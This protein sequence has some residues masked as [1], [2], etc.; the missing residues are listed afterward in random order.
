MTRTI[1]AAPVLFGLLFAP[2]A[3][4]QDDVCPDIM[5]ELGAEARAMADNTFAAVPDRVLDPMFNFD[6]GTCQQACQAA[7]TG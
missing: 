5:N 7:G 1:L 4:A 2:L 6:A 3:W